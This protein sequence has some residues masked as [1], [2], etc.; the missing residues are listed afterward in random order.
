MGEGPL[1]FCITDVLGNTLEDSGIALLDDAE[2]PGSGQLLA[3][4]G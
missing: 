3:C 2:A 1:S 4:G